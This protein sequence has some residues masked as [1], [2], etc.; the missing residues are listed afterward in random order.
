MYNANLSILEEIRKTYGGTLSTVESRR[1][2]WK[3]GHALIWT[4]AVASRL[5][6]KVAP[7]LRVKSKHARSLLDFVNHLRSCHRVRD[8]DGRLLPLS[9]RVL[10]IRETFYERLR[11]LN[12]R[13]SAPGVEGLPEGRGHQP[14]RRGQSR[15]SARYLAGLIDGEGCLMIT[16]S[17]DPT[18]GRSWYRARVSISNTNKA[19][20]EEIQR[21]YGG[22]LANQPAPRAEWRHA[23]QLVWT[24][25]MVERNLLLVAPYLRVKKEHVRLMMQ[26]TRHKKGTRQGRE[27]RRFAP[28]PEDVVSIRDALHVRMKELNAKG[29]PPSVGRSASTSLCTRRRGG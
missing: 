2:A 13:G 24:D 20:L 22:I 11:L 15:I 12:S 29:P 5:L 4:N 18:H 25:G 3:P 23:Y 28:L 21:A 1:L 6:E 16:R 10:E 14:G 19:V 26:F 27:G 8:R 9:K 7:Y 17:R